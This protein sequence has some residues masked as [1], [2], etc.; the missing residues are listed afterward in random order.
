MQ[1]GFIF[2][3]SIAGNIA[4]GVE[5]IDKERLR[6]AAEVANI[7]GFIEGLP[8]GYNTRIGQEGNGLSQGQKQR[9]LIARAVYKDPEFIFF[10]ESLTAQSEYEE[11]KQAFLNKQRG[12][13]TA[14][15]LALPGPD[16]GSAVA[17][18]YHRNAPTPSP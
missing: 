3:D 18:E 4:P 17:T 10:D 9:I 15:D 6:H 14:D 5:H 12:T 7:H 1:D 13:G 11:A 2:S 8:L 16:T